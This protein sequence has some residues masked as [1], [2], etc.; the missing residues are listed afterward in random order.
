MITLSK[1][2]IVDKNKT[3]LDTDSENIYK[4]N[5]EYNML[6]DEK[7]GAGAFGQI[8]KCQNVKTK[9][10]YAG[11]IESLTSISPQLYHEYK[12]LNEMKGKF[13]FPTCYKLINTK[14]DRTLIMDFLGPNLETIMNKMP[15]QKFTMKTAL[16]ITEQIIQRLKDL[17]SKFLLHRDMKPE[18]FVIGQKGKERTIFLI[19]FG[20]SRKYINERTL[21]HIPLKDKRPILGT[22]R[23]ISINTHLGFEQSRRDDLESLAYIMIYFI[24]GEL[25]W[26][27][28]KAKTKKEKY[29]KILAKKKE[30]V[31][32]EICKFLPEEIKTFVGNILKLDFSEK[33]DYAF[34]TSLLDKLMSKYGYSNDLQFDWYT[35]AILNV[36][37]DAYNSQNNNNSSNGQIDT[38]EVKDDKNNFIKKTKTIAKRKENSHFKTNTGVINNIKK[39]SFSNK[40]LVFVGFNNNYYK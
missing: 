13:G 32:N 22:V 26:Q 6:L 3:Y 37:Y 10:I 29:D 35:P 30:T 4:L 5:D 20:L 1:S 36:L 33:P 14:Q 31:P 38:K 40:K 21:E 27:C 39:K 19:D 28:I 12:I 24:M 25:P 9:E 23:Y 18:N 7:I 8:Y 11:K 17:H 34:L 16:M 2:Q 15:N